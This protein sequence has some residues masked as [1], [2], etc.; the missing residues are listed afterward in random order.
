QT[1]AVLKEA[2]GADPRDA[3]R[4]Q[5]KVVKQEMKSL[6]DT[7]TLLLNDFDRYETENKVCVSCEGLLEDMEKMRVDHEREINELKADHEREK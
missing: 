2:R 1:A 4:T 6:H 5:Q 7:V 3:T